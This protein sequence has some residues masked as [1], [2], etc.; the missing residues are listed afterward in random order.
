MV[1]SQQAGFVGREGVVSVDGPGL[2]DVVAIFNFFVAN[3]FFMELGR[4]RRV[5]DEVDKDYIV[6]DGHDKTPDSTPHETP[7]DIGVRLTPPVG[8]SAKVYSNSFSYGREGASPAPGEVSQDG[9]HRELD[10]PEEPSVEVEIFGPDMIASVL[11]LARASHDTEDDQ[12][13]QSH[14]D[15][16]SSSVHL[17]VAFLIHK[18]IVKLLL[19]YVKVQV[20]SVKDRSQRLADSG[21]EFF[22]E[23]HK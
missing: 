14:K 20:K 7:V 10:D 3:E 18:L 9:Q 5:A 4:D 21:R 19:V 15:V 12:E 8:A 6:K 17:P 11:T 1:H 23:K 13:D 2:V 16:A 22:V